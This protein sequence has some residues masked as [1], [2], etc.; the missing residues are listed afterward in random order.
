MVVPYI[1]ASSCYVVNIYGHSLGSWF[2]FKIFTFIWRYLETIDGPPDE[3]ILQRD[4]RVANHTY[5]MTE[6][7]ISTSDF[8]PSRIE[9]GQR[10]NHQS[11]IL[12]S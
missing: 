6:R 12:G 4:M 3:P 10:S 11:R 5:M 1:I 8:N 9:S 2:V 7:Q